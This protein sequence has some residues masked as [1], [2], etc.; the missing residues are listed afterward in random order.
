MLPKT[1]LKDV[2]LLVC[3]QKSYSCILEN[4]GKELADFKCLLMTKPIVMST[5]NLKK[6]ALK[7][8]SKRDIKVYRVFGGNNLLFLWLF[9]FFSIKTSFF[10]IH[11]KKFF[12]RTKNVADIDTLLSTF[13]KRYRHLYIPTGENI[14]NSTV[15]KIVD[16]GANIGATSFFY[17]ISYPD[18][19]IL[20][21]E[22]ELENYKLLNKNMKTLSK[23]I[24]VNRAVYKKSNELVSFGSEQASNS[25]R[26]DSN[27]DSSSN[28]TY[29]STISVDDIFLM[30]IDGDIDLLKIDIEGYEKILFF[31]TDI[32]WLN[33]VKYIFLEY[34]D[35]TDDELSKLVSIITSHSFCVAKQN[36]PWQEKNKGNLFASRVGH[37]DL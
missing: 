34:H 13:S 12:F 35:F 10:L 31:E 16:I 22:M 21:I 4:R 8:M 33:R 11:N 37:T 14:E 7:L 1:F 15:K 20:A 28:N 27:L 23:V 30:Y 25:F 5:N 2:R 24:T 32:S 6:M 36:D 18:A 3:L 17:H 19:Q 26:I 29:V 9:R